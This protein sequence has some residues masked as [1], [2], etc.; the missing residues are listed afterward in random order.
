MI[1]SKIAMGFL[2]AF[3]ALAL[4][5]LPGVVAPAH[6]QGSRKDDIVF[7]SRG[8]P[9]AGATVRVCAMPASGQPCTPLA[10]IYSDAALTQALAN[11]TTTDGL[12]NYSFY[13]APGKYEIEI[14][15][16]GITTKQIPNVFLP[17]DPSSPNFS[18][19][20]AFSL[21]LGG[22]LT[23][24]GNSTVIGNLASGT[25]NLSNQS[26]PPGAAGSGT[27]NLYTK[28]GDKLL[29]YKDET[30]TETGPLGPG[31]QTNV[32]NNWTAPQN[33]NANQRFKGPN[34]YVDITAF[35]A[36]AV[37]PN[38]APAAPGIT[39]NCTNGSASVTIS[40]ASTFVNGDGA[41]LYGCGAPHSMT[42]PSAPAVVPALALNGTGTGIVTTT[43]PTGATTYNYQI[44]A[45][46]QNGGLTAPSTVGST[47]TGAASLGAQTVNIT[48]MSRSG[49]TVTVTT[50]ATHGFNVG[51]G[52]GNCGEVYISGGNGLTNSSF[53]GWYLVTSAANGTTFTFAGPLD[54]SKGAATS[55]TGGTATYFSANHLTWS[56]VTGAWQYYIYSDRANPGTFVLVGV[57]RPQGT[58]T[59]LTWDDFGSPM[60]DNFAFPPYVPN[61]PPGAATSDHLSTTITGGA[62]TTTLTLAN[63]AGTTVSG[64][65]IRLDAGPGIK[66]A[67]TAA[68][69]VSSGTVLIPADSSGNSFVVNS[70]TDL[71]GM[72][73]T[74]SQ[75]G[76]LYLNETLE[77]GDTN[78]GFRWYG[79]INSSYGQTGAAVGPAPYPQVKVDRANPGVYF[80]GTF[81]VKVKG[82]TF[83]IAGTGS[84]G[85]LQVLAEGGFRSQWEDLSFSTGTSSNDL[86]GVGL[87]MRGSSGQTPTD[88]VMDK[89]G[90]SSGN[91][92]SGTSH[93]GGW[94]CI[95]CGIWQV[96]DLYQVHRGN[97]FQGDS[98][99]INQ[100]H[101]NGGG[102][103]LVSA[104]V[105]PNA[106]NTSVVLGTGTITMDTIAHPCVAMLTNSQSF[107]SGTCSP[108]SGTPPVTGSSNIAISNTGSQFSPGFTGPV[109]PNSN[110][111]SFASGLDTNN[112]F[113]SLFGV[114]GSIAADS[115]NAIFING[116]VMAQPTCS[117]SAGGSIALATYTFK[118]VALWQNNKEGV[119][120]VSSTSCT[121]TSGQQTITINWSTVTGNPKGYNVYWSNGGGYG[122]SNSFANPQSP[123][124]TSLVWS[125]PGSTLTVLGD[126][127]PSGGPTMLM[128]GTQG[129]AAPALTFAGSSISPPA[130]GFT[131]NRNISFPD[132]S[133]IIPVSSYQNSAYDN[134]TRAT[135]AIG[136]NWTVT[137]NGINISSNNFVGTVSN[138]N[139]VAY[140][141]VNTFGAP[142][143]SQVT[144]TALNGTT[145]FPGTA[146]LLSGSG[147]ATHGYSC[148]EDTTNIF[149]QKITGT[150]NTTLTSAATTGA[151]GDILRLEADSAGN[152]TCYKN[153]VST[154]TLNDTT[155]T[156]GSPGLFLF[157]TV[158]TSKNW[159]GGNLHPLSH[160]DSEQDWTKPQHFTQGIAL[161]GAASESFNNN[162]RAEQNVFLPGAL[163]S[164]WTGSTWT[165]DKPVTITRVQVQA[166]TAPSGCTTNAV[167]RLT[168]GTTPVN[169]TISAAANDSGAIAQNY[170][171]GVSLTVAVQTAAAG[172]T[173]SP[174]DANVTVQY[175]MQ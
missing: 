82:L 77:L 153:G 114:S 62:G 103:P 146:V 49:T 116:P 44:I 99:T 154:L 15:G 98:L 65:T 96:R 60:M 3:L 126:G 22:N 108:S 130:S 19:V 162:P 41:V 106:A 169:L 11:P 160:L 143:F 121:T 119:P 69:G 90:F 141:A 97:I 171:A 68:N 23:V 9:L 75:S 145:D 85:S 27:V 17:N 14:S 8:I 105:R 111:Y 133:G 128:S 150:A 122:S 95:Q 167:V 163:T 56:A 72:T 89:V 161:G 101:I 140:W 94:F 165:T 166:K 78:I 37:N 151:A 155:Y 6:A 159:S 74:L 1:R 83:T 93:N 123:T 144:L 31:A 139:D 136:S 54:A 142:Q 47:T 92:T 63:A 34:P 137:N 173:T 29:Y 28:T 168:D 48:S 110:S 35:G 58:N 13:A 10:L 81:G 12:G 20:S 70:F 76:S 124:T 175:R 46:D 118:V 59:D 91:T 102:T 73:F 152:L 61:T 38:A 129:I 112:L 100:A 80:P 88:A 50:A 113:T 120:S 32:A 107:V 117:V 86:M 45:R 164:T 138:A 52:A 36:R 5:V 66:A 39:A 157:G 64:A 7:N 84:N 42:T 21:N 33:F 148:V 87:Y 25:L 135:G 158:A 131:A 24:N 149:I 30:G 67:A 16:P 156:S 43:T 127:R 79:D 109:Q 104:S 55:A 57:S 40:S 26:T 170:A 71:H 172:C 174:A 147:G 132:N 53:Q 2:W 51:C 18:A 125:S 134:A 4:H 115:V